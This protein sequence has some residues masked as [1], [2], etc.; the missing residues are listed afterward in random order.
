M[1]VEL[2]VCGTLM[3]GLELNA[4]MVDAGATF[5]REATTERS[6]RMAAGARTSPAGKD[7]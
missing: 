7:E 3:R 1:S 6:R 5:I 2:A 4:N